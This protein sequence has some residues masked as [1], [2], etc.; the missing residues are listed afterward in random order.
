MNIQYKKPL[1][2]T[3][4]AFVLTFTHDAL[5]DFSCTNKMFVC[6]ACEDYNFLRIFHYSR[7]RAMVQSSA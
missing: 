5:W 7:T 6:S 4:V 1:D 3:S 2:L